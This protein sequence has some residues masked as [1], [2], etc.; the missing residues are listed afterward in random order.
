[1][2][3]QADYNRVVALLKQFECN[4][5]EVDIYI[6]CLQIPPSSVQ[7]IANK[8]KRNR[9]TVHSAV[10]QLI[11]KGLLYQT[12]KG[13]KRLIGAEPPETLSNLLQKKENEL[14]LMSANIDYVTKLLTSIQPQDRSVPTVKFYEG[15]DGFKKMLEETL[16]TK[17]EVLVFS[18]V[19][20]LA[21]LLK[22]DYLENYFKRR[23]KKSI[24]TRLIFPNCSFAKRVMRKSNEYKIQVRL[25]PP[26]F[27][28]QSGIFAWDNKLAILSYTEQ[29]LTCTI[30]ENN[31][32]SEFY[33]NVIF[34]LAWRQAKP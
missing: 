8:L 21:K 6:Q 18:Y 27:V 29:K 2:L 13:K 22:P 28:W 14:Q 25:L 20:L 34:E 4:P 26:E 12:R 17:R 1:M 10:D 16:K 30:I 19:E 32:I 15:I 3:N 9:V 24:H 11:E 5:Q 33:R 7:V 31:D 23:A